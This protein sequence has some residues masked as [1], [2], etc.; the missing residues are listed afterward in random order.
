[1]GPGTLRREDALPLLLPN[2]SP[3]Y[4]PATSG[5]TRRNSAVAPEATARSHES[6]QHAHP[7]ADAANGMVIAHH[8]ERRAITQF[9]SSAVFSAEKAKNSSAEG[10]GKS[11]HLGV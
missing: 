7:G 9:P 11:P 4:R 2:L 1:M 10:S 3:K 5:P 6:L 8:I